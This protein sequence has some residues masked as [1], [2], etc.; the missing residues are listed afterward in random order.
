MDL[1]ARKMMNLIAYEICGKK[2]ATQDLS[3]TDEEL[4]E[5]YKLA[6]AHDIAHIVGDALVKNSLID[7]ERIMAKYE[8]QIMLA[9]Y[10]YEK[11]EKELKHLR[12]VF[13]KAKIPFIVLKGSVIRNFYP[14]PWMRTSC[15]IDVLI[16]ESDSE[17]TEEILKQEYTY[18][19]KGSHDFSFSTVTGIH[20]EVHYSLIEERQLRGAAEVLKRIWDAATAQNGVQYA[21][22]DEYF[23]MY[24]IA[25]MAKHMENGGCGVRP[26]IDL[27]ILDNIDGADKKKRDEL[28][29]EGH[30]L[31]F[32]NAVRNL[33]RVWFEN[34]K[35]D[36]NSRQTEE[37]VLRGGVYGNRENRISVQQQKSG[38][39]AGYVLSK[40]FIPYDVI[41]FHY[42]LLQKHRWLTPFMEV[43]RWGKLIFC[44]HLK[45]V[46]KEIRY[47]NS[48]TEEEA[49]S[50][51][52]L[53]DSLGL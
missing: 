11:T 10:R 18:R 27:W 42:P 14:E 34:E 22:P 30:L 4:E 52:K 53:L 8:K 38:G 2:L 16:R 35:A 46:T 28:L 32:A 20:I 51:Q 24:H 3:L 15:D 6:K 17:K 25:H 1:I 31:K 39:R 48:I 7:N 12:E 29:K 19:C 49:K 36:A 45:R 9:I 23:Y 47:N 41:K 50:A 43:R 13:E 33:S 5:L 26:F 40:I 37:Y 44:G 21:V